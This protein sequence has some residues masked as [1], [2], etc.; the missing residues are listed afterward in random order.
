MTLFVFIFY[1]Y[2]PHTF[3][4]FLL[5][6]YHF[7]DVGILVNDSWFNLLHHSCL[8][9]QFTYLSTDHKFCKLIDY[10]IDLMTFLFFLFCFWGCS[11]WS[12]WLNI[13]E[14][15]QACRMQSKF[16]DLWFSNQHLHSRNVVV[17]KQYNNSNS[18]LVH[19]Q[20]WDLWDNYV[21]YQCKYCPHRWWYSWFLEI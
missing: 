14:Q 5:T 19:I 4:N 20:T 16:Y 1:K 2:F 9:S 21:N 10:K 13:Q 7:Q 3:Q 15:G 17:D 12:M 11:C 6:S 18:N 8:R